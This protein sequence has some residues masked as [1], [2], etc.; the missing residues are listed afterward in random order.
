VSLRSRFALLVGLSLAIGLAAPAMAAGPTARWAADAAAG[1]GRLIVVWKSAAPTALHLAGVASTTATARPM[2]SVVTA[3]PGKAAAVAASLRG[4]PRVLTVVP[5]A[6]L[7][8]LDWPADGSP[9]DPLYAQQGDLAQIDVPEAWHT[10]TGDPSVVVAVIDSGVDLSQPDLDGVHVVDARNVVWNNA[11]VTDDD[12]HGTH[13]TGTIVAETDNGLGMAGIAP[14]STL[15]PIKVADSDGFIA[16]SDVLDAVDWAREHGADVINLSLGGTLTPEQVEL[17]QPTFTAARDAGILTV[18]ASGNDGNAVRMYP[19]SFKGVVSVSAVDSTDTIADFSS[20]GRAVDIAAPGVD[21]LSVAAG[22][23]YVRESGT[24]MAAPHVTGVA[25]LVR[26]AR[27]GLDVDELEAV[28]RASAVDLGAPGH[29]TLYGDGRVDAAAALVEP[30]P[31]PIPD[32]DPPAPLPPITVAFIAPATKV[33]QTGSTYTV[34]LAITGDVADSIALVASWNQVN[35]KCQTSKQP[36]IHQVTFGPTIQLSNLKSGR[37]YQVYVAAIDEESN[38]AEAL[39][40]LIRILDLTAPVVAHRSPAPGALHVGRSAL[41]RVRFSEPVVVRAG[42]VTLRVASTGQAV[43][44]RYAWDKASNTLVLDPATSLS[45]HTRYRVDVGHGVVDR[46]G[47]H[48]SP[49]HWSFTTG[50]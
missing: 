45:A 10:T 46:G 18:A 36:I 15:M 34:K 40:P 44:A 2:R 17:A 14:G 16:L 37:C 31:D 25:A 33:S 26:A 13:V 23:G 21:L 9:S 50:S 48:L 29:D 7:S 39:S 49:V 47:N 30:V 28:L 1:D 42:D 41:V 38:Y 5:D 35:G 4:D 19:A 32:L 22:G 27:P 43:K 8:L 3:Q 12:G 6:R 20:T 24:S 11:D